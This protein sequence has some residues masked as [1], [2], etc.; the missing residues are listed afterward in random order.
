MALVALNRILSR[1]AGARSSAAGSFRKRIPSE[2]LA[3]AAG[4]IIVVAAPFRS[5]DESATSFLLHAL[6]ATEP[7]ASVLVVTAAPEDLRDGVCARAL[8]AALESGRAKGALVLPPAGVF[9]GQSA[10]VPMAE[11][12]ASALRMDARGHVVGFRDPGPSAAGLSSMGLHLASAPWVIPAAPEG[13]PTVSLR[14]L[15]AGR[16]PL[17]ILQGRVVVVGTETGLDASEDGHPAAARAAGAISGLLAGDARTE[18]P[19]AATG[20]AAI[21]LGSAMAFARRRFG[22]P[23]ALGA[24]G[25]AAALVLALSVGLAAF[26]RNAILPVPSFLAGLTIAF[27]ASVIPVALAAKRALARA[28]ALLAKAGRARGLAPASEQAFWDRLATFAERVHPASCALLAELPAGSYALEPKID[29]DRLLADLPRDV[30]GAPFKTAR[31]AVAP[32][33]ARG[34]LRGTTAP[35]VVVPL[36]AFGE[37]QGYLFLCGERAERAF[38]ESPERAERLSRELGRLI[39]HRR[40]RLEVEAQSRPSGASFRDVDRII[41]DAHTAYGDLQTLSALVREAPTGLVYADAFGDIRLMGRAFAD[42]L[43]AAGVRLAEK[44]TSSG[45]LAPGAMSVV[46]LMAAAG[47]SDP[48]ALA[49]KLFESAGT[50]SIPLSRSARTLRIQALRNQ[51]DGIEHIAGYI[52]SLTAEE[53]APASSVRSSSRMVVSGWPD[54]PRLSI[55]LPEIAAHMIPATKSSASHRRSSSSMKRPEGLDGRI[56]WH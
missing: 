31:G 49:S 37:I 2:A 24:L 28:S 22:V 42:D 15:D 19:L 21:L 26:A 48:S 13:V 7:P 50:V 3:V 54:D 11:L 41:E 39:R 4:A 12:P 34:I 33:V 52:L 35:A 36:L 20:L 9:C 1:P 17:S 25:G 55:P 47:A 8:P 29:R 18:A 56:S 51:S 14:D 23:G 46:D 45:A 43:A 32:H 40:A 10:S 5:G 44:G 27:A 16:I 53:R 30:R 6:R 38:S